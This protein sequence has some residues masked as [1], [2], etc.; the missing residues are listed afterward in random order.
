MAATFVYSLVAVFISAVCPSLAESTRSYRVNAR[1]AH[2]L[3]A[4]LLV[5]EWLARL[6]K[7][8]HLFHQYLRQWFGIGKRELGVVSSLIKTHSDLW[9]ANHYL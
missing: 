6:S 2:D 4:G 8:E 3:C 1:F 9:V 7:H 5:Q